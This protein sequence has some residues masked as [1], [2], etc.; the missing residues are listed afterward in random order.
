ME[1]LGDIPTQEELNELRWMLQGTKLDED[2]IELAKQSIANCTD[3]KEYT[4]LKYKIESFMKEY[5][6]VPNPSQKDINQHLR[7]F[8][9]EDTDR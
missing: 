1:D 4:R 6:D 5:E 8:I 3:F 9:Y 7:K 2:E